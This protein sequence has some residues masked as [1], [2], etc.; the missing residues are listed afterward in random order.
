[1]WKNKIQFANRTLNIGRF[2]A[3]MGIVNATPDSF[4]DGGKYFDVKS[5]V[6]R[7]IQL[8]AD[9]AV[10]LD[11]GGESTRPGAEEV[12]VEEEIRRVEPAI[13]MIRREL[14]GIILS[15]DTR[16]SAVAEAALAAGADI[17][18]DV[19]MLRFDPE[20]AA[21]AAKYDAGL[22]LNHSL[23]V[24]AEMQ[25]AANLRSGAIASRVREELVAA[26]HDAEVA[27]VRPERIILD[28]GIGFGKTVD[29]NLE[30]I[31]EL[32]LLRES[33][34]PV[35]LGVSRKSFIGKL[36]NCDV[37]ASRDGGTMG[38][39]FYAGV[40]KLAEILRIHEVKATHDAFAMYEVCEGI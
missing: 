22:I 3:L 21:V 18:N 33:G 29:Q 5:A 32:P 34:Y 2:P 16:K 7:G 30:L 6:C 38:I 15:V 26:A 31:A 9:G 8:A 12:P 23:A 35:L 19:S 40:K 39:S 13:R 37:P 1:M 11:I 10:L 25:K 28:P 4:S 36:L 17:V 27:G 20:L 14:P 24:P